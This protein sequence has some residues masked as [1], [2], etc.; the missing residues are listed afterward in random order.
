MVYLW[1]Q[2]LH[3]VAMVALMAGLFY[4]PRLYVY[5]AQA[6]VGSETSE[7]F[8]TMEHKLLRLIMN[9]AMIVT[10]AAGLWLLY[11]QPFWLQE[12]WMHIKLTAVILMTA[13]HMVYARWRKQFAADE[14]K[15]DHK[16]YRWANEVPTVLLLIIVAMVI[17]KPSFGG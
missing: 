10:W 11:L 5:H 13:M 12:G 17:V 3:V 16:F 9:P 14:N 2:A 1:V 6:T 15:R 7:T 4:L 8:K